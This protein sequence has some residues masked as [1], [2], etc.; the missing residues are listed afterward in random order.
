MEITVLT[1]LV[2]SREG[3][4]YTL[5]PELVEAYD[6]Y[7]RVNACTVPEVPDL[8]LGSAAARAVAEVAAGKAP[9]LLSLGRELAE[10]RVQREA[11]DHAADVRREAVEQAAGAAANLCRD[12]VDRIIVD[13]LRPALDALHAEARAVAEA[14]EGYGLD[15][16]RLITAPAKARNAYSTLPA[17][18]ARHDGITAA[19]RLA[20]SLDQRTPEHDTQGQFATFRDPAALFPGWDYTSSARMPRIPFPEDPS[21]RLL[22][23]VSEPAQQAQPWLPTVTEQDTAWLKHY[24][25]VIER[26][27]NARG[28]AEQVGARA[29]MPAGL[30][31]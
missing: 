5:P 23:M 6:T 9:D 19:R 10:A 13:H 27:R 25:E 11:H 2:D 12:L 31:R 24:G 17:L 20:N 30:T 22:W 4:G 7:R 8:D 29:P 21:A 28:M 3:A 1:K 16:H 14:L 18:V 15:A 26:R